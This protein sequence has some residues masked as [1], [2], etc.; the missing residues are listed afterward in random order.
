MIVL[1]TYQWPGLGRWQEGYISTFLFQSHPFLALLALLGIYRAV[2]ARESRFLVAG[3][4]AVFVFLLQIKRMRY[5][6]PLF[7]LFV[8]MAAYGLNAFSDRDVRRFIC[9]GIVASSMVIAYFAYLPFLNSTSVANLQ[10]AGRYMDSLECDSV[11][12]HALPQKDSSGSTFAA[13]PILDH[14]TGKRIVSRQEWPGHPENGDTRQSSLRFTWET[15]KPELY[16]STDAATGCVLAVI[17]SEVIEGVP[18]ELTGGD[19]GSFKELKR[20][21]LD[22]GIFKY[23]TF[24]TVFAKQ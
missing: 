10:Q 24:V 20:F 14:H 22:S 3:W 7:P 16:S 18:A 9:L 12:V 6:L 21:D 23:R 4:F 2:R 1:G 11:E 13:I 17:S 15:R 5:I 8:L 19:R